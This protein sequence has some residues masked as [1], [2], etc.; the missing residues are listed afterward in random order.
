MNVHRMYNWTVWTLI[1]V[2]AFILLSL[3]Q[4][5]MT[6]YSVERKLADGSYVKVVTKSYRKFDE[7]VIEY[8]TPDGTIFRF[9]AASA[10][11]DY[12]PVEQAVAD[13]IRTAPG[14]ILPPQ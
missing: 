9:N 5:C 4:G 7:P 6:T 11:T 2:C 10:A 1:I 8:E 13:V 14:I 3:L 12:S